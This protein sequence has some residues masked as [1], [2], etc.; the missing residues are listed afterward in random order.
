ML[1]DEHAS[2][3]LP[4]RIIRKVFHFRKVQDFIAFQKALENKLRGIR[5]GKRKGTISRL[6]FLSSFCD[7]PKETLDLLAFPNREGSKED[8]VFSFSY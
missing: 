1:T 7:T 5:V 6:L 4:L 3:P 8:G 2:I